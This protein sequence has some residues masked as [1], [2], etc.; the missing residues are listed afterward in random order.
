MSHQVKEIIKLMEDIAP[1]HL[2]ES[3]DNVGLLVGSE[4]A[5]VNKV[6]LTLDVTDDVIQQAICEK[7]NLIISHHPVLFTTIKEINDRTLTGSTL[8]KLIH[9]GISV[10]S[11]HTNFDKAKGG[12]D[13]ILA[14]LLG[15]QD[16]KPLLPSPMENPTAKLDELFLNHGSDSSDSAV[17]WGSLGRIGR[18]P[19][20]QAL[21][22]Y[23]KKIKNILKTE[24]VDFIGDPA[25][26]IQIVASCAGAGGDFV[27]DARKAGAD[28]FITGE[29]KYHE[30]LPI[31]DGDMALATF[32][33]Y[34]T[35]YPAILSLK[36]RLQ[37][38]TNILQWKVDFISSK[39]YGNRF[40]R[41]RE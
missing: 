15:I 11:A 5:K 38:F 28:L 17:G 13:D 36:R 3:W 33:H 21:E 2:A 16:V 12:T 40:R 32:G 7:V 14:E 39:D 18:L 20:A 4:Q 1:P 26:K 27:E 37:N 24:T 6:M 8:L 29:V 31:L 9:H 10:Y 22:E 19:E 34:A 41:L 25:R 30:Q 35:E 23:L